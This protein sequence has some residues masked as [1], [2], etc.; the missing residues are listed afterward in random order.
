MR[1]NNLDYMQDMA[2]QL[3]KIAEATGSP[4]LVYLFRMA[5]EQ[6]A[7]E[8]AEM[9]SAQAQTRHKSIAMA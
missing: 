8:I 6:A 7:M 2:D 1:E 4:T 3:A 5:V 9:R